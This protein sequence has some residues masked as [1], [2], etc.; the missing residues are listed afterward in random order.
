MKNYARIVNKLTF[1][2]SQHFCYDGKINWGKLV[3]Y[4]SGF[5]KITKK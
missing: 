3:E 5:K 4:N 2:F 1:G